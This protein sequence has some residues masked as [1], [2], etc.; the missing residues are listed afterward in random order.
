MFKLVEVKHYWVVTDIYR[1]GWRTNRS[2]QKIDYK[3]NGCIQ[4]DAYSTLIRKVFKSE[5][6]A[7]HYMNTHSSDYLRDNL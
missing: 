1:N 2:I 7:R 5:K 6:L 4:C 3:L